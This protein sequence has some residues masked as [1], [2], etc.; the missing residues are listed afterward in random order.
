MMTR[1]APL[2]AL[3]ALG[4]IA[5][6]APPTPRLQPDP[7]SACESCAE[8]NQRRAPFRIAGNTYFVGPAG[9]SSVLIVSSAGLILV[10]GALPQSAP[11]IDANIRALG[12]RTEELKLIVNGHAHHDHAGGIAA[13]QRFTGATVAASEAGARAL[14][15]GRPTPDDP[16]AAFGDEGAFPRVAN[17]RAVRDGEVLRVGDVALTAHTTPG[18]T[19][20]ST[21]TGDATH[22]S[23]V[24]SI[25]ASIAKVAALPC[26]ILVTAHPGVADLDGKLKRRAFVDPGAC[27]ALAAQMT[28]GLDERIAEEQPAKRAPSPRR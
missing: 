18:H 6:A 7:P 26:D 14:A 17:V 16:Q 12:F 21:T 2:I 8:W 4:S 3:A 28:A 5:Q 15:A 23:I 9:L 19:P 13:L 20:V 1:L 24:P 22:P 27:R 10:D 11:L 25:R